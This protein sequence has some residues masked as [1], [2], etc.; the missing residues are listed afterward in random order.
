MTT[1]AEPSRLDVYVVATSIALSTAA[2]ALS[3]LLVE[4]IPALLLGLHAGDWV[5]ILVSNRIG[6]VLFLLV[7]IT[8]HFVPD[9]AAYRLGPHV[10]RIRILRRDAS[11]A[12]TLP[13]PIG[14]LAVAALVLLSPSIAMSALAGY[15][16]MKWSHFMLLNLSGTV[17]RLLAV[18]NIAGA[19]ESAIDEVIAWMSRL[20]LV[21]LALG[22]V[23]FAA[24][25][26]LRGRGTA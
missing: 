16:R 1:P 11:R 20:Q 24:R 21:I 10:G 19:N 15:G 26:V 9:L 13:V 8:R 4:R 18:R 2:P 17:A 14:W 6:L 7:G 5:L 22:T 3:G 25:Y 23:V 12:A